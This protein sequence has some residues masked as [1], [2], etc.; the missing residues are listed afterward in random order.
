[1]LRVRGISHIGKWGEKR[2][3]TKMTT[4]TPFSY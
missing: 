4:V 2:E 3:I 1:M